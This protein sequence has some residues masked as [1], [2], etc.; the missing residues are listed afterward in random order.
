SVNGLLREPKK[1]F[2][3]ALRCPAVEAEGELVKVVRQLPGSHRA[4]VGS[5][6]PSLQQRGDAMD[7]R[8]EFGSVFPSAPRYGDLPLKA[9]LF[10]P[11]VALPAV[12][13][14]SA[15]WLNAIDDERV[16]AVG[17]GIRDHPHP[18]PF[19]RRPISLSRDDNQGL[20]GLL[21]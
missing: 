19:D 2:P 11:R 17:G 5:K 15:P 16:Q 7:A 4:L 18:V 12:S 6:Q 9:L 21:S 3:T 20:I 1:Q 14:Q 10:Q 8:Q 13:V